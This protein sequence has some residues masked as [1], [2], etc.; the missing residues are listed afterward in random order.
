MF[1][2]KKLLTKKSET[3]IVFDRYF[4]LS[5]FVASNFLSGEYFWNFFN[6]LESEMC[7][8]LFWSAG[9]LFAVQR[10][11]KMIADQQTGKNSGPALA[12]YRN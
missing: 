3:K 9:P 1:V 10:T 5:Q 6:I 7:R 11:T 2:Q 8:P 12:N 4:W